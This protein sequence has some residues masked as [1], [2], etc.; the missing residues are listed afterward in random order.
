MGSTAENAAP[1]GPPLR[2]H[3]QDAEMNIYEPNKIRY[4][5]WFLSYYAV[6]WYVVYI[7]F[8]ALSGNKVDL[9]FFLW[10]LPGVLI[11]VLVG[12]FVVPAR[13]TKF[14]AITVLDEI[15]TG[16]SAWFNR[17][18]RFNLSAVDAGKSRRR[19]VFQRILGYSLIV[20]TSGEKILFVD[21]V[22]DKGQV[23]EILK[24]IGC[25]DSVAA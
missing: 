20:S 12:I 21:R 10:I 8:Q 11:V 23:T 17:P 15:I 9:A 13:H 25:A 4:T 1:S 6:A 18:V 7:G 22:F 24:T 5:V 19:N 3:G 2:G 14:M 16:P